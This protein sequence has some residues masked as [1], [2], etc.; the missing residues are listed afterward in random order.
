MARSIWS[1]SLSFGLVNVPVRL[2][3][4]TQAHD[5]HFHQ[6]EEG[7]GRRVRNMRVAEG[8]KDEVAYEDVVK[9]Y[10]VGE[11]Q[12]VMLSQDELDTVEPHKSRT[13]DIE[14]FVSLDEI[15]PI[16]F[17]RTY[18]L[19]PDPDRGAERAYRLLLETLKKTRRVG[20]GRFVMRGKEYLAAIRPVGDVLALE[21]L[22]F[23]D[24]VRDPRK[25]IDNLPEEVQ[26]SRR[27]LEVAGQLVESLTT[28]W[29]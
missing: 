11:D 10:E 8:T 13:I 3:S 21:T 18:Y 24:E 25:E 1:G 2:Y 27:E 19:G 14:D 16:Y 7:S 29:K 20:I 26:P 22:Y 15:D 17:E 5:I 4:A 28:K 12:W 23:G 9:G 6:F